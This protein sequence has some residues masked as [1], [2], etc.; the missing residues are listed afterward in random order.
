MRRK[1]EQLIACVAMLMGS[2]SAYAVEFEADSLIYEII[3]I[4]ERTVRLI[5][6]NDS[7]RNIVLRETAMFQGREMKVVEM[8]T[9]VGYYDGF[10]LPSVP[11]NYTQSVYFGNKL[12]DFRNSQIISFT[13]PDSINSMGFE[14][15][16]EMFKNCELLRACTI[17]YNISGNYPTGMFEGCRRLK[18]VKYPS[19]ME[20]LPARMFYGSGVETYDM[21]AGIKELGDSCF[22]GSELKELNFNEDIHIIGTRA[23]GNTKLKPFTL[24]WSVDSLRTEALA[25]LGIKG[26]TFE[27]RR[28]GI[29]NKGALVGTQC[30]TLIIDNALTRI[31]SYAT[32][33]TCY[34][35]FEKTEYFGKND[36]VPQDK[37]CYEF[38][39]DYTPKALIIRDSDEPIELSYSIV[40]DRMTAHRPPYGHV[41]V[42]DS[43]YYTLP[44]TAS[45]MDYYYKGRPTTFILPEFDEGNWNIPPN[46]Y[47]HD[48]IYSGYPNWRR[49]ND[50]DCQYFYNPKIKTHVLELGGGCYCW[51]ER[52]QTLHSNSFAFAEEPD[53]LILGAQV[54]EITEIDCIYKIICKGSTPPVCTNVSTWAYVNTVVE[55][56]YGALSAYQTAEG[57]KDF[58]NLREAGTEKVLED[59]EEKIQVWVE[60]G[61]PQ[62]GTLAE[63]TCIEVYGMDGRMIW[64]GAQAEVP[65]LGGGFYI[66][67]AGGEEAK[68]VVR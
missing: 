67:R 10:R 49:N 61:R 13:V 59:A 47:C 54:R 9:S 63:E 65:R 24:P 8:A 57:W 30:D 15:P 18:E 37:W 56:P 6:A 52:W 46:Y 4:P 39:H 53:T 31:S 7:C 66:L 12:L 44:F 34:N 21:P 14:M 16:A 60:D 58:F 45:K 20:A 19:N 43:F 42:S 40:E 5:G 33:W 25:D 22:C 2:I 68:F 17:P 38:G 29:I 48:T 23:L 27:T 41:S 62:I 28:L 50:Y 35:I 32:R 1:L 3:S 51:P 36:L 55:V 64:R 11:F 26:G